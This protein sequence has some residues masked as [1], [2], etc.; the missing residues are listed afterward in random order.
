M[1]SRINNGSAA[2]PVQTSY[3]SANIEQHKAVSKVEPIKENV[4]Q[5]EPK[6]LTKE[7]TVELTDAMNQFL[8]SIDIELRF[9]FHDQLNE[10][11]VTIVDSKTNEVVREVPPKKM[12]DMYAAMKD[13]IGLFV[14]KK[15]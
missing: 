8:A 4:Q 5:Q 6:E 9:Q 1:V 15:I 13:F 10:Y 11:Y 3:D 2:Q 12:M 7:Q 14:D